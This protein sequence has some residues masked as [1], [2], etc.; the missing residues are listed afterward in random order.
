MFDIV[1]NINKFG[2]R[3]IKKIDNK[4]IY[5]YILIIL[6]AFDFSWEKY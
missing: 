5:I 6:L 1:I 3:A 4:L 2:N